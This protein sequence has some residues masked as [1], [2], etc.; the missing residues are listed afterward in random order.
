VNGTAVSQIT[1]A[2]AKFQKTNTDPKA[3]MGIVY[4]YDPSL[5]GKFNNS[6][7]VLQMLSII[8]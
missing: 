3:G 2:S 5:G 1:A 6:F 7:F 8:S 4:G